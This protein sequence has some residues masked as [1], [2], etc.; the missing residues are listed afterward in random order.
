[1]RHCRLTRWPISCLL[2][3]SSQDAG[4]L[5]MEA[6]N[7]FYGIVLT[8][9]AGRP[10]DSEKVIILAGEGASDDRTCNGDQLQFAQGRLDGGSH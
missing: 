7:A 1:M 9:G 6:A 5:R 3:A 10:D 8:V 2:Y 4:S